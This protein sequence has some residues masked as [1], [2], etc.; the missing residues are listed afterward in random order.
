MFDQSD[1]Y[2]DGDVMAIRPS[3]FSVECISL[4]ANY[5][6]EQKK[7]NKNWKNIKRSY[8]FRSPEPTIYIQCRFI[9]YTLFWVADTYLFTF[10]ILRR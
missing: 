5:V 2:D 3:G 8:R 10:N 7:T 6:I 9:L 4:K 1:Y